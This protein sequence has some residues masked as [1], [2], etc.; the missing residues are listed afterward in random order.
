VLSGIREHGTRV[1]VVDA[2]GSVQDVT[3]RALGALAT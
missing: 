3:A 2:V 1:A